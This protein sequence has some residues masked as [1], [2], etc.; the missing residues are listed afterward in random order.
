VSDHLL[1][2]AAGVW[3]ALGAAAVLG[4]WLLGAYNRLV[5]LRNGIGTAWL[6]VAAA[7]TLRAQA[8]LPLVQ[9]LRQ[10]LLAESSALD[11]VASAHSAAVAA[12]AL[13]TARPVAPTA[14]WVQ[15]EA[16]LAASASRLLSLIDQHTELQRSAEVA[17]LLATWHD[18]HTQLNFARRVFDLAAT[19]YNSA[20]GQ[21][22]TRW[23]VPLFG[24]S[25]AGLLG[26]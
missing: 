16:A 21:A 23:L 11:T 8:A 24:F 14:A 19:A 3:L 26:L 25:R 1:G 7:L 5:A 10:P 12:A 6:Q 18:A 22:P 17:A 9:T 20:L 4:F 15:A 13:L 2:S